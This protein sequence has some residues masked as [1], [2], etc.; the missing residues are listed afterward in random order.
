MET[1]ET[2]TAKGIV[3]IYPEKC[4]GCGFCIEFCPSHVLDFSKEFNS[5]GYHYP[6]DIA[7]DDCSG[8]DLC[9]LY[10]PDFAIFGNRIKDLVA[11]GIDI[12]QVKRGVLK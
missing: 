7:T 5:K 2:K 4:K 1:L 3:V 6:V 9:G 10:C 12:S 8:C 11:K